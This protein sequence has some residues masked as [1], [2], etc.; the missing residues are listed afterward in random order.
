MYYIC[1]GNLRVYAGNCQGNERTVAILGADSIAGLDCLLPG[2]TSLMTIACI[3]DSWLMPFHNSFIT[4]L[5][6]KNPDFAT[7]LTQYYCKVMRQLCFD[8]INQS[9][10]SVF[11]RLTNFLVTNWNDG[12]DNQVTLS[13]Q[14]L[15]YAINC[16]RASVSR[17]CKMLKDQGIIATEGIGFRI[18]DLAKLK[19]MCEEHEGE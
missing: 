16:S 2:Q 17:V 15:A 14:E 8:A 3:T 9:I 5:I 13:Q 10:N 7:T 6:H 12:K 19:Q 11:I 1:R 4:D 18:L